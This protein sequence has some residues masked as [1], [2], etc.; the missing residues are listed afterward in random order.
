MPRVKY[1][2]NTRTLIYERIYQSFRDKV[3]QVLAYTLIVGAFSGVIL[4]IGFTVIDS[5]KEKQL[6]RKIAEMQLQYELLNKQATLMDNKLLEMSSRDNNIYRAVLNADTIPISIRL[7]GFGGADRYKDLQ[8]YA[9]SALMTETSK[10]MDILIREIYVQSKSYDELEKLAKNKAAMMSCIPAIQPLD[11][12]TS[13]G[14][15]SGFGWRIHPILKTM[16]F[17]TG[18]DFAASEGTPIYAT[19]DGVVERADNTEE[20][21]G[22]HVVINH[23]FGYETLYG[24]MS[25]MAV[26]VGQKVKRG[27]IIG[28]VGCTGLCSGD[29]VHYEVI[30][31]G[32]KVNPIDYFYNDMSPEEYKNIVTAAEKQNQSLD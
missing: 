7:A 26:T 6:K 28:Y 2:F 27:Q 1:I 5:P 23:G 16:H 15:V 29:H 10:K 9:N 8:G 17:H 31:N 20:G 19:G 25:R 22:N 14:I 11:A 32:E 13:K 21:Y 4:L 30:K 18:V 3:R 24:H 12:K